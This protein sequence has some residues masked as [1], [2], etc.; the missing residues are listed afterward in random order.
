M[1]TLAEDRYLSYSRRVRSP[2]ML[3]SIQVTRLEEHEVLS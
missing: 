1:Q 2:G 3:S